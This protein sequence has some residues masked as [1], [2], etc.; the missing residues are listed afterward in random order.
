MS[1][2][3][4]RKPTHFLFFWVLYGIKQVKNFVSKDSLKTSITG[5][6]TT[7]CLLCYSRLGKRQFNKANKQCLYRKE[8]CELYIMWAIKIIRFLYKLTVETL[9]LSTGINT[10]YFHSWMT[11]LVRHFLILSVVCFVSIMIYRM[12]VWQGNL[13]L[14]M[15][16]NVAL[17]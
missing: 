16:L 12:F 5:T 13:V 14:W 1:L 10:K 17:H 4:K 11:L 6:Q 3:S 15:Y 8:L 7:V 2:N 9:I